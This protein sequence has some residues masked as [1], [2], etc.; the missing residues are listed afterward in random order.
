MN[1]FL[2]EGLSYA[3]VIPVL[4]GLIKLRRIDRD[5]LPLLIFLFL[6]LLAELV[7]TYQINR[8]GSNAIVSNIYVL[9]ESLL[10]VWQFN[11]WGLFARA[12]GLFPFFETFFTAFWLFENF[13]LSSID[14]FSSYFRVVYSFAIVLMSIHTI[15]IVILNENKSILLNPS[16]LACIAFI[17]YFTYKVLVEIFWL[18]GLNGSDQFRGHIY[19]IMAYVNLLANLIYAFAILWVPRKQEYILL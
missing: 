16:F 15:N 1:Y 11:K 8:G 14:V 17:L 19:N 13:Y 10:I 5:Y 2:K 7:S 4:F 12:K 6:G 18:Y 9:F 3:I